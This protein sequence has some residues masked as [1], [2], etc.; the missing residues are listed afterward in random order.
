[1]ATT[2]LRKVVD[3][4]AS[5]IF[6]PEDALN[7]TKLLQS[8]GPQQHSKAFQRME[9]IFCLPVSEPVQ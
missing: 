8:D 6:L 5:F 4:L 7:N 2:G 9:V 3:S 1:M